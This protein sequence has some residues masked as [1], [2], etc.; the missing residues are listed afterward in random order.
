MCRANVPTGGGKCRFC[1]GSLKHTFANLGMQPLSNAYIKA[2]ESELGEKT[3]PLHAW[4]CDDCYLVQL[5]EYESPDSIFCDYDYFSSYSTSWLEHA[6]RYVEKM[7]QRFA[8]S[9]RSY[10]VEIA[11]NDGYLL[12]FFKARNISALGIEPAA[13]VAAVAQEKGIDT[14]VE[15]FGTDTAS[16]LA[17][18]RKADLLLG[19]NVLAHVPDI[20]DFVAGMKILLAD[21]GIITMEFPHLLRLMERNEFDTIYHEHFS[22]LSFTTV[23]RIFAA[24]GLRLFDVEELS[25]H[26]GSLRIYACHAEAARTTTAAVAAM[27]AQEKNAGLLDISTYEAFT[28]RVR[29]V[30]YDLLAKLIELKRAGKTIVAYGAAAKGNTLLNY[31]GVKTDFIDYVADKSPHKQNKLLPG[32]HIPIYAPAKI[33]ET[34]PDYVLVL[35]WNLR[36]E[37][38]TELA[39]IRSWSG[40]FIFAIPRFEV[41]E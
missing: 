37:I 15:F 18:K 28:E 4:V 19:N 40:K 27:L 9:E 1:G 6:E 39:G 23:Q 26:G 33:Y 36:E 35:P 21:D 34:K 32:S 2:E 13:N 10:V 14:L 16:R 31:C 17:T 5:Q 30:K 8:F 11:S 38:M 25:T 20:N 22:Y 7:C 3:Y 12:Q 41:V 24:H 29:Q